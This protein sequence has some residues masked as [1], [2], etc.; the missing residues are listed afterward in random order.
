MNFKGLFLVIIA[1]VCLSYGQNANTTGWLDTSRIATFKADSLKYS[2]IFP[3]SAYENIRVNVF[4]N[5]T[6]SA[7]FSGDSIKFVWGYRT[8]H[9]GFTS[10]N[11]TN[12]YVYDQ[13]VVLDTFDILTA[14]NMVRKRIVLDADYAAPYNKKFIDTLLVTSWAYQTIQ[15][16]PLWDVNIQFF[17]K[18]LTGNKVGRF[19]PLVFQVVQRMGAN[20]I[21]TR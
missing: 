1:M 5:D 10:T 15:F 9:K 11:L 6:A 13:E 2:K 18:G 12:R 4:A 7:G 3:L 14:G 16:Q 21:N 8:L 20:T 19:V 17:A